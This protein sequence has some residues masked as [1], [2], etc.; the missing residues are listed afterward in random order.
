MNPIRCTLYD[1]MLLEAAAKGKADEP[2]HGERW[3]LVTRIGR[4]LAAVHAMPDTD[5]QYDLLLSEDEIRSLVT[6]IDVFK[7]IGTGTYIG[8]E[9]LT[10]LYNAVC[11]ERDDAVLPATALKLPQGIEEAF[12]EREDGPNDQ[13]AGKD[14]AADAA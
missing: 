3:R 11:E 12:R 5:Q 1:L 7:V 2:L 10:K 14:A 8:L 13:D 9:C 4:G 6:H